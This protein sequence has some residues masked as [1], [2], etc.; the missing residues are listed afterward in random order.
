MAA[1]PI[2]AATQSSIATLR[3]TTKQSIKTYPIIS[4]VAGC[5]A[6]GAGLTAWDACAKAFNAVAP[7]AELKNKKLPLI[8]SPDYDISFFGIEKLHPFDS[9]KYGKVHN[10]LVNTV[11]IPRECFYVPTQVSEQDLLLVHTPAYLQSL[12]SPSVVARIAENPA[13]AYLPNFLVQRNLLAPMKVA[14]G[15]TILGGTLAQQYGWAINL[16]G[17]YHHAKGCGR[18]RLK[19]TYSLSDE[20][21]GFCVFADIPLVIKKLWE[22]DPTLKVLIVD[23]DAHQGNGHE[24]FFKKNDKRV[25]IFDIYNADIY[26][27]DHA[28]KKHIDFNYPVQSGINDQQY[29][30]LLKSELPKAIE[31]Y[32]PDFILY[33]AG[34]DVFEHDP[35]GLMKVTAQGII[36][37][38]SFVFQQAAQNN[39]PVLMLLSG[40]YTKESANIIG[41]SVEHIMKDVVHAI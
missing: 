40:G 38:D 22:K 5:L 10:Y 34:T 3:N 20:G 13:L 39:T 24:D 4:M 36:E 8:F 14:T 21:G 17:G 1:M 31:Q 19:E 18:D 33:N 35:L 2:Q 25:A 37:R 9:K 15:G 7:R 16:A 30:D 23:L 29:L 41:H 11:G 28:A 6:I 32:K 12:N 27:Y 26:P